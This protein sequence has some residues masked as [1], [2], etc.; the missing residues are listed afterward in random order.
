MLVQ[1]GFVNVVLLLQIHSF[2]WLHLGNKMFSADNTGVIIV[3]KTTVQA[4]HW[5]QEPQ[6]WCVQ[7]VQKTEFVHKYREVHF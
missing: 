7:K 2:L 4:D 3:W 1:D 5:L 6:R